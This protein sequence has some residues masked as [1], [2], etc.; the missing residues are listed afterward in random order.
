MN[1]FILAIPLSSLIGCGIVH[2]I[3][4]YIHS[5]ASKACTTLDGYPFRLN[6]SP[7][8]AGYRSYVE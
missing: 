7:I 2:H 1:F 4:F 3:F 5:S 6:P 8:W